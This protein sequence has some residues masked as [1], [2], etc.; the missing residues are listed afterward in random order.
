[1]WQTLSAL[2]SPS[3]RAPAGA[4]LRC[5]HCFEPMSARQVIKT[6]FD[7]AERLVCCH[8]CAAVLRTV[9]ENGLC[10][11]YWAAHDEP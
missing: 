5:F 7:G 4:A 8:G 10:Q 3:R 2:F 9:E 1:M 6:A 11:P